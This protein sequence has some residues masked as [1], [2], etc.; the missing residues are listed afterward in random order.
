VLKVLKSFCRTIYHSRHKL[1]RKAIWLL[2]VPIAITL[3]MTSSYTACSDQITH[4]SYNTKK[5][6][7]ASYGQGLGR[8]FARGKM[9]KDSG[10]SGLVDHWFSSYTIRSK[11][12]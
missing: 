1:F 9:D 10:I 5:R 12:L 6:F 3:Q 8:H 4:H 7:T 11:I 2:N